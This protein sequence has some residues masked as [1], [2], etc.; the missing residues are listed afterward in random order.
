MNR[1]SFGTTRGT[2]F[3]AV[4]W[5]PPLQAQRIPGGILNE[6]NAG[7]GCVKGS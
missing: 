7:T 4:P 6:V 1:K 3:K 5:A 2:S